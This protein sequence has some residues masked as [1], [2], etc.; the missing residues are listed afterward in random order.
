MGLE[1]R[2]ERAYEE[3]TSVHGVPFGRER[4]GKVL[5]LDMKTRKVKVVTKIV[6][7][8]KEEKGSAKKEVEVD[9]GEEDGEVRYVDEGDD[10]IRYRGKKVE[11]EKEKD[12]ERP[13]MNSTFEEN[14]PVWIEEVEGEQLVMTVKEVEVER[15]RGIPGAKVPDKKEG[16]KKKGTRS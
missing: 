16:G 3:G 8:K 10:G 7:K 14:R 13:F 9:V 4:E 6:G 11:E 12:E 2:I 5:R 1:R 15:V